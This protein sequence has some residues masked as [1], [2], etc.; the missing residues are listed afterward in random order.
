VEVSLEADGGGTTVTLAHHGPSGEVRAD[1][2][3]GWPMVLERLT[4]AAR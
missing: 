3:L 4:E 2:A 1:H